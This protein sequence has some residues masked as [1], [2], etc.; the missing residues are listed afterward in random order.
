MGETWNAN[1]GREKSIQ[2]VNRKQSERED[3]KN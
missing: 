1:G 2:N 3:V